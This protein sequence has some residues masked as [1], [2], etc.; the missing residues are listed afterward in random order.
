MSLLQVLH[1]SKQFRRTGFGES[2]A[3]AVQALADVSF[4]L[5]AGETLVVVGG[6][7]S[8]KTTLA[9]ILCKLLVPDAGD[10]LWEGRS[11]REFARM[12]WARRLQMV[13]QDPYASLNPKL[14]VGTQL[15]EALAVAGGAAQSV[16]DLLAAVGLARDLEPRYPFQFSGGQRQR[17]AIARALALQPQLLIL[18]EPLSALDIATQQ[19]IV[20]LFKEVHA[21]RGMSYLLIT[22]D[23][24]LAAQLADRVIVLQHGRLVE[25]GPAA[26]VLSAPQHA[27]TQALVE[28]VL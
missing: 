7:G 2:S 24:K 20:A 17:I 22:H 25:T 1:L 26:Q 8:G 23:L 6:S 3:G 16:G 15:R 11:A 12:E 19:Q 28:A 21:R 18:D 9:K 27:Y 10:V 4:D 13:F 5:E 14:S